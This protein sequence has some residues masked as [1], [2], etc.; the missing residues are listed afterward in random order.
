MSSPAA[1]SSSSASS[2]LPALHAFGSAIGSFV[3]SLSTSTRLRGL[4]LA[5]T[6]ALA[7][8]ALGVAAAAKGYKKKLPARKVAAA[9]RAAA[10][11]GAAE[12]A[13]SIL[14]GLKFDSEEFVTLLSSFIAHTEKLQNN[15]PALVPREDLIADLVIEYLAPFADQ[16]EVR[17]VRY[18]EGRSNVIVKYNPSKAKQVVSFV[19]SHMVRQTADNMKGERRVASAGIRM[20]QCMRLTPFACFSFSVSRTS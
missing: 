16:L 6:A 10:A 20:C 3:S 9:K 5:G 13:D 7:Y 14:A 15:P 2:G 1:A 18:V 8:K 19:G 4:L 11:A 12:D 17:R